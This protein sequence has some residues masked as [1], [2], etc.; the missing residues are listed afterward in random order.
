[1]HVK[2]TI[3]TPPAYAGQPRCFSLDSAPELGHQQSSDAMHG[4]HCF[5]ESAKAVTAPA[6]QS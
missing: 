3:N 2:M 6:K 5:K 4:T 1:M